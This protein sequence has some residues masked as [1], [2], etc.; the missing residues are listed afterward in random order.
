MINPGRRGPKD[1]QFVH[2]YGKRTPLFRLVEYRSVKPEQPNAAP[3][4][5]EYI[6]FLYEKARYHHDDDGDPDPLVG[7]GNFGITNWSSGVLM[8]H[9]WWLVNACP[10]PFVIN[11]ADGAV[12]TMESDTGQVVEL[13]VYD[14][15][16]QGVLHHVGFDNSP[17]NFFPCQY[18][19]LFFVARQVVYACRVRIWDSSS[20][21]IDVYYGVMLNRFGIYCVYRKDDQVHCDVPFW[22]DDYGYFGNW[23]G[24]CFPVVP[25]HDDGFA[26]FVD[27]AH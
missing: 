18:F 3:G 21:R 15:S 20:T 5:P 16:A 6:N 7:P 10:Q 13:L 2:Q 19:Y 4:S 1:N 23:I 22:T 12:V 24:F 9:K 25:E 27:A 26:Y 17:Y 14:Y 8:N 11:E